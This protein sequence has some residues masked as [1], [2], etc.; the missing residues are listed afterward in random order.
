M[1]V[2]PF[3]PREEM[4]ETLEWLTEVIRTQLSEQRIALRAAPRRSYGF[5]HVLDAQSYAAA[6]E[7][8]RGS[9]GFLV[10]DWTQVAR[11]MAVDAGADV[12]IAFDTACLDLR[13]G[14]QAILWSAPGAWEVIDVVAVA[15]SG[16]TA[17]VARSWGKVRLMPLRPARAP[18]GLSAQRLTR[19]YASASI[20]LDIT[21][22]T[23]HAAT[24]YP[25][26]RGHDVMTDCPRIGGGGL[27]EGV[28]WPVEVVDNELG[29][30]VALRER[31]VPDA[32]FTMRWRVFGV[33]AIAGLR[34]WLH[35][36]RG[37]QKAFWLSSRGRDFVP[38]VDVSAA[39]TT[40]TVQAL[41]GLAALA[42]QS[43]DVELVTMTGAVI[44]RRVISWSAD[45]AGRVVLQLD[46][47][48]GVTV[49]VSQ[50]RRLSW[51][52]CVRFNADRIELTHRAAGGVEV[53][54]PCLEVP[55]P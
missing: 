52:R 23:S 21:E 9:A 16:I 18:D 48:V 53:A 43:F 17:T 3:A 41:P 7:M 31:A 6:Q 38:L 45:F 47:A 2:W 28:V 10:P 13:A 37:R 46:A 19:H 54:I 36:R 39:A 14:A 29:R 11:L 42:R 25:Q 4:T 55:V 49:Q 27:D 26:Y 20:R 35:S 40:V 5:S 15:P 51:L 34:A 44:R 33:C 24:S 12:E 50:V 32:S 30:V 8:L 22:N 1:Q